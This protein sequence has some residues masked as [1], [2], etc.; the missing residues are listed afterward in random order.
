MY[1]KIQ[2]NTPVEW[3][4]RDFQI[5]SSMTTVSLPAQITPEVVA[6]LG[7]EPYVESAKPDFNTLVEKIEERTP[8]KQ[9]DTWVQQWEVVQ[10]YSP[11]EREQVLADAAAQSAADAAVALQQSIVDAT[12]TRLDEFAKTRNYDS[13]LSACTYATDPNP[14][15]A[16]E[17]QRAVDFRSSTWAKLYSILSEVQAGT[18]PTPV[19][20]SD[21][22][23]ELPIL[24]WE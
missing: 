20:F 16:A 13:I 24:S 7:F 6:P 14:V 23:S 1:A 10:L 4:V 18:R 22:E 8:A 5:R 2:N 17:G 12:Q 3:P 19:S 9:G 15:F 21:I 11:A